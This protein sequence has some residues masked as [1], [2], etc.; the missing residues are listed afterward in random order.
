MTMTERSKVNRTAS[1]LLL[2]ALLAFI[3]AA[4]SAQGLSSAVETCSD[5]TSTGPAKLD[6]LGRYGWQP[7]QEPTSAQSEAM[8]LSFAPFFA[9]DRPVEE[10]RAAAPQISAGVAQ[11]I[12]T[13]AFQLLTGADGALLIVAIAEADTGGEVVSCFFAGPANAEIE[14]EWGAIGTPGPNQNFG[15]EVAVWQGSAF[16]AREDIS[17]TEF[18]VLATLP[19]DY[20]PLPHI[21]RY[22]RL[23]ET[24]E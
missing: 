24:A 16:N 5:P 14:A 17:Y 20:T 13:G 15:G 2:S 1:K 7:V 22:E 19:E 9:G 23:E 6:I 21:Y 11:R 4:L 12:E 10:L 18:A 8:G 3:P